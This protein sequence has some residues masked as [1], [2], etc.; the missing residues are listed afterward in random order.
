MSAHLH[1]KFW[2][3]HASRKSPLAS[4]CGTDGE[5]LICDFPFG[6]VPHA[7]IGMTEPVSLANTA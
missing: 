6:D 2:G 4:N 3:T 7:C 5:C 1:L